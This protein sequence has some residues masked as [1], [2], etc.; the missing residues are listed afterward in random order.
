MTYKNRL[1]IGN[2]FLLT[3]VMS[4]TIHFNKPT[5]TQVQAVEIQAAEEEITPQA[6]QTV[7]STP[8]PTPTPKPLT[9]EDKI[10]DAFG[11][12]GELAIA[13]GM[14][15][16]HLI[17]DKTLIA[18]AGHYSW[19]S[20]TY[21]GEC[22]IGLFMINLAEDGCEGRHIHASKIPGATLEDKIAW[23]KVPENNIKTA[24][25]IFDSRGNFTAWSG[26]TGG[27]YLKFYKETE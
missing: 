19:S 16:S 27:G 20:P 12:D 6:G 11:D 18:K 14:S 17:P 13:V 23:L 22:S 8:V 2:F 4:G 21:K 26:Y 15:E 10:R 5:P 1:F 7:V 24:K 25:K 9:I 3:V